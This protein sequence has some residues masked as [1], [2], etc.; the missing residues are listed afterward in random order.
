M[1][2]LDEVSVLELEPRQD[3]KSRV[4]YPDEVL[5]LDNVEWNS[6]R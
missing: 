2:Y 1:R 4:C 5:D 3:Q 6:S